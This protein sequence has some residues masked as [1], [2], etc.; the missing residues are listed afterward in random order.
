MMPDI[1]SP[2]RGGAAAIS[3][4]NERGPLRFTSELGHPEQS[5]RKERF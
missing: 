3:F 2:V 5:A 4:R 1:D